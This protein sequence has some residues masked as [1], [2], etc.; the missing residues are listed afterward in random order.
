[1]EI[2]RMNNDD[3][4]A[5]CYGDFVENFRTAQDDS[6]NSP[7]IFNHRI[8]AT[9][10]D[11]EEDTESTVDLMTTSQINNYVYDNYYY[12]YFITKKNL[13][14]GM[15]QQMLAGRFTDFLDK[16]K[17][18]IDHTFQALLSTYNPIYNYDRYS[19]QTTEH[20]GTVTD[21][22]ETS[23]TTTGQHSES[24]TGSNSGGV[25]RQYNSLKE[26][27][28]HSVSNDYQTQEA[29]ISSE[30]DRPPEITTEHTPL[31]QTTTHTPT[32]QT[33]THTP[34]GKTTTTDPNHK[35]SKHV[36]AFNT[37]ATQLESETFFTGVGSGDSV[38]ETYTGNET[39]STTYAGAETTAV[40]Y[41]NGA[42]ITQ[43]S[44]DTQG[45]KS[46]T[47]TTTRT[48]SGSTSDEKTTTG[49]YSDND[50]RSNSQNSSGSDSQTVSGTSG[51]EREYNTLD[52]FLEKTYGNIGVTT[53]T[54]MIKEN[55]ELFAKSYV[56]DILDRFCDEIFFFVD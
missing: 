50:T 12:K 4:V 27:D 49:S 44:T 25:T 9:I 35:E 17:N 10:K 43:T 15:V 30:T 24:V 40:S 8:R 54:Q 22:G 33:V 38:T 48:Q 55:I 21:E 29:T 6:Y 1:M 14:A 20:T 52:T 31:G 19:T 18:S 16:N 26:T 53:S 45:L 39:T 13:N 28:T 2:Q 37:N 23:N 7:T 56:E 34:A 47:E 3:R 41:D 36:A 32:G 51:N 5:L 11:F 42:E 46:G